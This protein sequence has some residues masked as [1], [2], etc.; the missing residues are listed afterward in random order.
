MFLSNEPYIVNSGFSNTKD[1]LMPFN[2]EGWLGTVFPLLHM[3]HARSK[4]PASGIQS[5]WC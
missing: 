1:L 2:W 4:N 5:A 3:G